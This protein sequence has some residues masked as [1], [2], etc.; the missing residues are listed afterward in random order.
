MNQQ[1]SSLNNYKNIQNSLIKLN[2]AVLFLKDVFIGKKLLIYS[3]V[4][5]WLSIIKSFIQQL[6]EMNENTEF[7]YKELFLP[8]SI[9]DEIKNEVSKDFLLREDL[10]KLY[11]KINTLINDDTNTK[12]DGIT[13]NDF[14]ILDRLVG[15]VSDRATE[16]FRKIWRTH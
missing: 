15:I 10:K 5:D 12:K 14:E 3:E 7:S 4:I 8:E 11:Q 2:Y 1:Y 16:T 6:M 9:L 13:T